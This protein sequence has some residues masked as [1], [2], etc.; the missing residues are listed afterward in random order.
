MIATRHLFL[1]C[2]CI[3]LTATTL[4]AAGETAEKTLMRA[5]E[6]Y[7]A[8]AVLAERLEY[9]VSFPDGRQE[10]KAIE[11]ARAGD[12]RLLGL[13][14]PDGTRIFSITAGEEGLRAVQFN[15]GGAY[16][17]VPFGESLAAAL[18]LAG[19]PQVGVTLPPAL[20]ALEGSGGAFVRSFGFGVLPALE[21]VR[22]E[23]A[24]GVTA[25]TLEAEAGSVIARL[26]E[27]TARLTGLSLTIG[28]DDSALRLEGVI[29]P[30]EVSDGDPRWFTD[31]AGREVVATFSELEASAFPLGEM[32]PDLEIRTLEGQVVS[33]ASLRGR[34][35][36]LDFWATWCVPC[37][38]GLEG[39]EEV[40]RWAGESGKPISV[41]AVDTLERTSTFADQ[42]SR[43]A[44]FL[45]SRG[46]DVPVLIDVDDSFFAG[47]HSPGLPSTVVIDA[48]GRLAHYHSGVSEDLSDELKSQVTA[49]LGDS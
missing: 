7:R 12:R 16:V 31:T 17:E 42:T 32:A 5:A 27:Q 45:E 35:V 14:D 15:V 43:A 11:Y 30:I 20:A 49:L 36:V 6:G 48:E 2:T 33:L 40:A 25:V 3:W 26:D 24:D 34:V 47:M 9:T 39:L 1:A 44:G 41:W 22:V 8:A 37:W 19:G 21:P 4:P 23:T 46:L 29:V 10:R 28:S 13:L 38:K 18:E